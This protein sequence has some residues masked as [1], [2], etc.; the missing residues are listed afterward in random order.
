[1]TEIP[2]SVV[3]WLAGGERGI[4]SETIVSHIWKLPKSRWGYSHPHDPDDLKRCLLLLDAS[5]ETRAR[6]D[7]M[8]D[9][10][11]E[12]AALVDRWSGIKALFMA[13]TCG[14]TWP[15]RKN[16]VNTYEAMKHCFAGIKETKHV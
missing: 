6:F 9:V 5:P 15:N 2:S 1:M 7:E 10:S 16:A 14:I 13:E 12:W 3:N 4:S 8:R 11:P